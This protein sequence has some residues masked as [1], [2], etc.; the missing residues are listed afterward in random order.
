MSKQIPIRLSENSNGLYVAEGKVYPRSVRGRFTRLREIAAF[1]LLGFFYLGPWLRWDGRQ[2][3]LG[4]WILERRVH[5][6]S[7]CERRACSPTVVSAQLPSG[8][9]YQ[10]LNQL[11]RTDLRCTAAQSLY[12]LASGSE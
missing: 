10:S 2:A 6:A 7:P 8:A 11:P 1:V 12:R 3:I 4:A 9:K 5:A